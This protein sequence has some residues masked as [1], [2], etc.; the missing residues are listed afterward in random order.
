MAWSTLYLEA[1]RRACPCASCAGEMDIMGN[2]AKGPDAKLTDASF[3]IKHSTLLA[4]MPCKSIGRMGTEP[5][6]TPTNPA[7]H[8]R[9]KRLM[10]NR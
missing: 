6:C 5:A 8:W 9:E 1:L 2:L 3:Q 4:D 7:V 10:Q